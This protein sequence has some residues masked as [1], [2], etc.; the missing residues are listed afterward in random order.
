MKSFI[1]KDTQP[2]NA[3]NAESVE[4]A[5][6]SHNRWNRGSNRI[7]KREAQMIHALLK[8]RESRNG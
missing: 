1:V 8:D 2:G 6:R 5:I 4:H 3:Y 7:G